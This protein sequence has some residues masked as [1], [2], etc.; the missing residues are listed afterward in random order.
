MG[1]A[2][3]TVRNGPLRVQTL[4]IAKESAVRRARWVGGQGNVD[5]GESKRRMAHACIWTL[6]LNRWR[7]K[8]GLGISGSGTKR[9]E[10]WQMPWAGWSR[11]PLENQY[12]CI[13]NVNDAGQGD[14]LRGDTRRVHCRLPTRSSGTLSIRRSR[15][16]VRAM[17]R[18]YLQEQRVLTKRKGPG[19]TNSSLSAIR[20]ASRQARS[21]RE[22]FPRSSSTQPNAR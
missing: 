3:I 14:V 1:S 13:F 18:P 16:I 2:S 15:P 4:A 10:Q 12:Y 20:L 9:M 7:A 11:V 5:K 17:L 21:R 8:W 6:R 19:P 22:P